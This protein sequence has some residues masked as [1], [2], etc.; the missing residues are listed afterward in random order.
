MAIETICKGCAKKLRVADEFAGRKARCPDCKTVYTVPTLSDSASEGSQHAVS[1]DSDQWLVR[2][3]DGTTYGPV[4]KSELDKWLEEGRLA[5][6]SQL[7]RSHEPDWQLASEVYPTLIAPK[8]TQENPFSS[9]PAFTAPTA[10]PYA[11]SQVR[12][13]RAELPTG[14]HHKPHRGG[15]ILTFGILGFVC[16]QIFSIAAWVMGHSDMQEINAGRMDPQGRGL[17]QAGMIIGMIGTGLMV[18]T[19]VVQVLI[20]IV[21]VA[22]S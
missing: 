17:T 11:S 9:D 15:L 21:A 5:A 10:N 20:G 13:P 16:C 22:S 4:S 14:R 12:E 6:S 7:R 2:M 19:V 8:S 18:L 3:A 1:N